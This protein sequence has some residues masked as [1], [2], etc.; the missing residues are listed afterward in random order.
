MKKRLE[1]AYEKN[2]KLITYTIIIII[3]ILSLIMSC[4]LTSTSFG[5]IGNEFGNEGD[6]SIKNDIRDFRT[7]RNYQLRFEKSHLK[8]S[9]SDAKYKLRFIEDHISPKKFTC[10]TNDAEVATC[11]VVN[12]HVVINP[13]KEGI[14]HILLE[15]KINHTIYQAT[16]TIVIGRPTKFIKLS[17]NSGVI[18]LNETNQILVGYRLFGLSGDVVATSSNERIAKVYV[19]NGYLKI[20]AYKPGKVEIKVMITNNG[21]TYSAIYNLTVIREGKKKSSDNYL[22]DI[23]L[24]TGKLMPDF[25]KNNNYYTVK[26]SSKTNKITIKGIP[27]SNKATI[28]YNGKKVSSLKDLPLKYGDNTVV[29]KVVAEDG[30]TRDYIINIYRDIERES[31]SYLKDIIVTANNKKLDLTPKFSKDKYNYKVVVSADT[32]E[33]TIEGILSSKKA[34]IYYNGKKVSSLKDLPLKYGDNTVVIKVVAEDGTTRDYTVN[35]YRESKYEIKF[36]KDSYEFSLYTENLDC[37]IPYKVYKNGVLIDNYDLK[38]IK[39]ELSKTLNDFTSI[40]LPE[41]GIII[42]KPDITKIDN[43]TK[44]GNLTLNYNENKTSTTVTFKKEEPIL[45]SLNDNIKL[46]ISKDSN[47]KLTGATDILLNTNLFTGETTK[48]VSE[49]KKEIVICSKKY[50]DTCITIKTNS[51]LIELDY[52]NTEIGPIHL[53]ITVIGNDEGTAILNVTGKVNGKEFENLKISIDIIRKYIV[54]L[55]ANGGEFEFGDTEIINKITKKQSID[56][57]DFGEPY[58]VDEKDE[59]KTYKFIGYSKTP[60]GKVIYN[61]ENK[62]IISNLDDDLKL[63]AIYES[64]ST[65]VSNNPKKRTLWLVADGSDN[66]NELPIFHNEKYF[67]LHKEDKVIYP[68]ATGSYIMNF[69][70]DSKDTIVI[71]G[72]KLV[73]DTICIEKNGCLNM[74]YIIKYSPP[75][76]TKETIYYYGKENNYKILNKDV[77]PRNINYKGKQI[78]FKD[79]KGEITLKSKEKVTIPLLWKWVEIDEDSDKL[80]TLIGNQAADSE[81]DETLN[82]KYKISIGL[83][84]EIYN[85]K[86]NQ[87]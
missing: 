39:A 24:S 77:D 21:I 28:Y 8:M 82:D 53:P 33:A 25:D 75:S 49:D 43:N 29:I 84:I 80:D 27:N 60:D 68:G 81:Y 70:N 86:C 1:E 3:V 13:K 2:R 61:L 31:N 42:L 54:T 5:R 34:T 73:E 71:K 44:S 22:K 18:N 47:G 15:T 85:N 52:T 30:T 32:E 40:E 41:K 10:T 87:R 12:D 76:I 78:N 57:S 58:K 20:I 48:K 19:K 16:A 55:D 83:D 38:L 23:K 7:I 37:A 66:S 11:Y 63:Y 6:F 56:L 72:I 4:S 74:G 14:V 51:S 67:K 62:K 79:Y 26:V 64:K 45:N 35:I 59:C 36:D 65:S 17:N 9:L 46:Y 50:K 69:T